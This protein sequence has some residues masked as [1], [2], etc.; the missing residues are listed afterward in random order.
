MREAL[1]SVSKP[2][3]S[4]WALSDDWGDGDSII[5]PEGKMSLSS[6]CLQITTTTAAINIG[7]FATY[8]DFMNEPIA[9][10]LAVIQAFLRSELTFLP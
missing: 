9:T 4:F 8:F 6:P 3:L 2:Y 1:D 10:C 5:S 7:Y